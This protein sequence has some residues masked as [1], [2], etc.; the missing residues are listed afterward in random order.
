M[1]L[2]IGSLDDP[3]LD[4]TAQ[5]N[6]KEIDVAKSIGWK[7]PGGPPSGPIEADTIHPNDLEYTGKPSRTMSI[8]LLF[9]GFEEDRSIEPHIK[10]LYEM[11]SPRDELSSKNHMRRPHLCVVVWNEKELPAF[12]CV[13]E[14]IAVKYTMFSKTGK[15]L[16]ATCS[17]K[18]KETRIA[19]VRFV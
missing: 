10:R 11:S 3:K 6:P 15:P 4:V 19:M 7:E 9:D 16:R 13:I 5:Y 8:E 2:T 17:V 18:L 12:R 1:K 14:S